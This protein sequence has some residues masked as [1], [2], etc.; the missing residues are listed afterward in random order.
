MS[1]GTNW[2]RK[3]SCLQVAEQGLQH[4]FLH[5]QGCGKLGYGDDPESILAKAA[6]ICLGFEV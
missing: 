5:V 1:G 6:L 2:A 4:F 3:G